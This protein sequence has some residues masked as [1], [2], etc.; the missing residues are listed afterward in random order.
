MSTEQP[1]GGVTVG[2][3]GLGN[4]GSGMARRL[5]GAGHPVRAWNRSPES[6]AALVADGA[7]AATAEEALGCE[8]SFS[9]LANDEAAIAV[10]G[11][12]TARAAAGRIHV[13]MASIS[14]GAADRVHERFSSVGAEY[15]SA[16]VLGRPNVAAAGKLN[17]LAAGDN[18]VIAAV[19][20]Y[21]AVLG[22]KT[23]RLGDRPS[24]ANVVKV[25]VNYN[26]IHALQAIGES[27]AMV[28][29]QGVEP[30]LFV[31]LLTSSLFGG[32]AYTGYGNQIAQR[33]YTP[34][35]FR[36]SLGRKDLQLAEEV[37]K[38]GQVDLAT[39]PALIAVFER[40]LADPELAESDW[41]AIAEITRRDLL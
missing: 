37:A 12:E 39:L 36:M 3:L 7:V 35:G 18:D 32:V 31:E 17:I 30:N 10:L 22:A 20:P 13:N 1:Q 21:L 24:M 29:R 16:P 27:V 15:V 40:A 19:E 2:F 9:M 5:L 26:L 41:S 11:G 34:P 6:V 28:E 14:P 8:V 25:A 23:W 38:A 33:N 4:M